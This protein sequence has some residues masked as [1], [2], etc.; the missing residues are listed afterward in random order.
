MDAIAKIIGSIAWPITIVVLVFFFRAKLE[1]LFA[2][3]KELLLNISK[4]KYRE[5]EATFKNE[6]AKIEEDV[7]NQKVKNLARYWHS[8]GETYRESRLWDDAKEAYFRSIS[9]DKTYTPSY[10]G[11]ATALREAAK[12]KSKDEQTYLL[13]LALSKIE[14]AVSSEQTY[15]EPERQM[16]PILIEKA[17]ILVF[18]REQDQ[19]VVSLEDVKKIL[20]NAIASNPKLALAIKRN[21]AFRKLNDRQWFAKLVTVE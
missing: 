15:P 10:T 13:K 14:E 9:N 21:D 6:I 16:G 20:E 11:W 17:A 5:F 4:V 18:L 2:S 8:L 1:I 3:I 19:N 12:G 7:E